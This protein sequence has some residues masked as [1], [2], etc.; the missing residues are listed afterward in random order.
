MRLIVMDKR[1]GALK[2]LGEKKTCFN[3]YI[4]EKKNQEREDERRRQKKSKDD[5]LIMLEGSTELRSST[6]YSKAKEI[7][8][9][10]P[11]WRVGDSFDMFRSVHDHHLDC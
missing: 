1:Y 10:D 2:S 7:F 9:D 3:E 5:F 11:R 8:E 4:Q 6:R